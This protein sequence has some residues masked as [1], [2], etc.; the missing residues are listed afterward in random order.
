MLKNYHFHIFLLLLLVYSANMFGE[1]AQDKTD[2]IKTAIANVNDDK[3][4]AKLFYKLANNYEINNKPDSSFKYAYRSLK[5]SRKTNYQTNIHNS[6]TLLGLLHQSTSNCDSAIYYHRKALNNVRQT[7]TSEDKAKSYNNLALSY[8]KNS[9]PDSALHCYKKSLQIK[10]NMDDYESMAKTLSNIGVLH[11]RQGNYSQALDYFFQSLDLR[12]EH[13]TGKGGIS[14]VLNNIGSLYFKT[15]KY[16]LALEY[17]KKAL[18]IKKEIGDTRGK[19]KTSLNLGAVYQKKNKPDTALRYM[20]NALKIKRELKHK[21]GIAGILNNIAN[22]HKNQK[23]YSKTKENYLESLEIRRKIDDKKGIASSLTNLGTLNLLMNNFKQSEQKLKEAIKL[24]EKHDFNHVLQDAYRSLSNLYSK[25]GKNA[26]ALEY[27]KK[28]HKLREKLLDEKRNRPIEELEK[29]YKTKQKEEKLKRQQA[30]LKNS[31]RFTIFL[32]VTIALT[33]VIILLLIYQNRIRKRYNRELKS[34]NSNLDNRVRI[35]TEEL[36]NENDM[37]RNIE[38]ELR[39]SEEKYRTITKTVNAGIVIADINEKITFLN[40]AFSYMLDYSRDELM[41]QSLDMIVNNPTFEKFLKETKKRQKGKSN[42]YQVKMHRKD[43]QE[44]ETILT[45]SPLF[46]KDGEF[47]GG[48]GS[49]TDITKIKKAENSL[50]NAL[51]KSEKVNNIK[52]EFLSN[53]N[54]EIRTPLNNIHGM[55]E[56]LVND[57]TLDLSKEQE[58]LLSSIRNSAENVKLELLDVVNLSFIK[59]TDVQTKVEKI[60]VKPMV[61]KLVDSLK[62]EQAVLELQMKEDIEVIADDDILKK[63]M[64]SL[65]ENAINHSSQDNPILRITKDEIRKMAT[66]EFSHYGQQF[67]EQEIEKILDPFDETRIGNPG[68]QTKQYDYSLVWIRKMIQIMKGNFQ[69]ENTDTQAKISFSLP[70]ESKGLKE[71]T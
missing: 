47:I 51:Y 24:G 54:E 42:Q 67:S 57:E 15:E 40:D 8:S 34:L 35:R 22:L 53:I 68:Q 1:T 23:N 30:E 65:M 2:S 55:S 60:K 18:E 7:G 64:G 14:G 27:Y 3:K 36:Q 17:Y 45:A 46:N 6:L 52:N 28:Y 26:K 25:K 9:N 58:K 66:F 43:G 31:R 33:V 70:L 16:D 38:N 50:R 49:I 37:R 13:K 56:I 39:E 48:V 5:Q 69:F 29:K 63:I 19:A 11:W 71:P 59:T 61:D 41:G 20:Q 21:R 32:I 4:Q 62:D 10:E 44:L 12:K